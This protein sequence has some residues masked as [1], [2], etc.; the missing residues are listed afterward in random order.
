[1]LIG[2]RLVRYP[3]MYEPAFRWARVSEIACDPLEE[4]F[5]KAPSPGS[6]PWLFS[7]PY[8]GPA[9]LRVTYKTPAR[10]ASQDDIDQS[11]GQGAEE[12]Q[13]IDLAN[14]FWEFSAVNLTLPNSRYGWENKTSTSLPPSELLQNSGIAAT[15][16]I[17]RIE[18]ALERKMLLRKPINAILKMLGR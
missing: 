17:P 14:E 3:P 12:Q 6:N 7:S 8:N 15:K 16:T 1:K 5:L 4:D 11:Q 13:E 2:G 10:G 18:F 9:R